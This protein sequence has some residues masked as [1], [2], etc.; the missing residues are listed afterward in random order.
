MKTLSPEKYCSVFLAPEDAEE[1]CHAL[2]ISGHHELAEKIAT[3]AMR[4]EIQ[5]HYASEIRLLDQGTFDIDDHP[6]VSEGK[7]GAYVMVWQ[8]IAKDELSNPETALV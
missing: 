6:V 7:D 2:S 5:R 1:I 3:K 8:W 4:S